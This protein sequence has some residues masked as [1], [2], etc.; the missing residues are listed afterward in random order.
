MN[1]TTSSLGDFLRGRRAQVTP[2]MVGL[3]TDGRRRVVG[4]RREEVAMLAGI[5]VDYYLRLEQGRERRPSPQVL[6]ALGT[7]LLLDD[8]ARLHLYRVA[9]LVPLPRRGT[10]AERADRQLL[11]LIELWERA[12]AVVLGRAYDVLAANA[13][14]RAVFAHLQPGANLLLTMFLNPAVRGFHAD[15]ERA[16]ANTVAGFRFLHGTWP[17]DPRV[18]E[19]LRIAAE[20]SPEFTDLWQRR[21]ARGKS[22]AAKTLLHRDVGELALRMQA[23][24][25]RSAPG[26]QL[27]VYQPADDGRTAQALALLGSLA[28]TAR[29]HG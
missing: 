13:L 29:E 17:H 14:G 16:A 4:L 24:D 5:S 25:V 19:V 6:D 9:G 12:P 21:D 27:V 22:E 23:F 26:Q 28:A 2:D 7:V 10:T 11:A 8:D 18:C 3:P 1:M 15:W 20:N